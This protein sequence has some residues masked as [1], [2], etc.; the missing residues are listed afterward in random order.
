M[1][2]LAC[3]V[4]QQEPVEEAG[5]VGQMVAVGLEIPE[6]R[7][8]IMGVVLVVDQHPVVVLVAVQ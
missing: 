2:Q 3:P 8:E 6:A 7:V 1:D 4:D 5:L